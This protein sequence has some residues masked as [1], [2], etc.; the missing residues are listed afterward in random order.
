MNCRRAIIEHR[1]AAGPMQCQRVYAL[2]PLDGVDANYGRLAGEFDRSYNRI[3]LC[4]IEIA[5]ELIAR[6]PFFN[7][8][9]SF[10]FIEV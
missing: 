5:L 2:L 1:P 9:E 7:Q 4:G 6:F 8:Q 3:E 10:A